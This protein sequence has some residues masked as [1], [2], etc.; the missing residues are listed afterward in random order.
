MRRYPAR[1]EKLPAARRRKRWDPDDCTMS[2]SAHECVRPRFDD[3]RRMSDRGLHTIEDDLSASWLVDWAGAGI[4]EL[5][6]YLSK[7]AAF[8]AFLEEQEA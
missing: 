7:H 1:R 6:A 8:L 5:E 3:L 2:R 4:A